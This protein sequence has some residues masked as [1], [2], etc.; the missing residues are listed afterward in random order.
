VDIGDGEE[1]DVDRRDLRQV[2]A[3]AEAGEISA[4]LIWPS[5]TPIPDF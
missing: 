2:A 1:L 5:P 4:W 3:A